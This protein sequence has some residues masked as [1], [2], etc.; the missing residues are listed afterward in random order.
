MKEYLSLMQAREN[1]QPFQAAEPPATPAWGSRGDATADAP[2]P[3]KP[4]Q[5]PV[6][7]TKE[8]DYPTLSGKGSA[9]LAAAQKPQ[10]AAS[11]NTSPPPHRSTVFGAVGGIVAHY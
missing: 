11:V 5:K 8:S 6:D 4:P 3:K 1:K 9:P 2:A 7:L 10:E